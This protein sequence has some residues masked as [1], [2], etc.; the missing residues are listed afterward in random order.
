MPNWGWALVLKPFA[1]ILIIA[2][3]FVVPWLLVEKVLRPI[4]P[5]GRLKDV[6]FGERGRQDASSPADPHKRALDHAPV[7][8]RERN[9]DRAGL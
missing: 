5:K 4:F 7:V 2:V 6:L 1:A 3:V 9:E 8:S